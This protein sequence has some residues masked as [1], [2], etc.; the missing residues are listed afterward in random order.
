MNGLMSCAENMR[1]IIKRRCVN[2][3]A[4]KKQINFSQVLQD[5]LKKKLNVS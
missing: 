2:D 3:A 1:K 5:A 4:V